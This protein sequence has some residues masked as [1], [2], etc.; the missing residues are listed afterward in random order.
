MLLNDSLDKKIKERKKELRES[1]SKLRNE[2]ETRKEI[3][4]EIKIAAEVQHSILPNITSKYIRPEF[5]L[6]AALEAAKDAAGDFYDFF[7]LD[8]GR[9]ALVLADVSGKGI[10]AALFMAFAKTVLRNICPGEKDPSEALIKANK[11][12]VT[13]NIRCMFVTVFLCYY[14]IDTG[15]LIYANAG[16]HEAIILN[17]RPDI[18]F[19]RMKNLTKR[20][21]K[22]SSAIS[23]NT[24]GNLNN[25][26][27]GVIEDAT[28]ISGN[29]R[30]NFGDSVICY[31][32]GV[33]EAISP[34]EEEYGEERL[35][36]LLKKN[37]SLKPSELSNA[38][39]KD[40]KDFEERNRFDDITVLIFKRNE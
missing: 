33:S 11:I 26:P 29:K 3:E 39:I 8:D 37:R 27:L 22:L 23:L 35:Y 30:L 1:F 32:D 7:Y 17:D 24:F 20:F 10:T 13:D 6:Y 16:H 31:T 5:T 15:E 36:K 19:S 21:D 25:I 9:L 18:N 14:N 2:V 38:I 34:E 12:L 28:Y 4:S 40:V